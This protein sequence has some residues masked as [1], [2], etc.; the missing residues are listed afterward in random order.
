MAMTGPIVIPAVTAAMNALRV[1]S[2]IMDGEVAV[3]DENGI[4]SFDLL[5][6]GPRVKPEAT[7]CAFDLIELNGEDLRREALER[8]KLLLER[9][10]GAGR[11]GITFC[12][13]VIGDGAEIFRR[14]CELG[15]EG[16]V[17]KRRGSRYRSGRS[18]DR[19]KSKN[20]A[21]PAVRREAEED[22]SK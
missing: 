19:R 9:L 7:F 12:D 1:Q 15:L 13:H 10:L 20:P 5:R 18:L 8:R 6:S 2:C 17:S 14:V 21:S 4:R 16:I 3:A 11:P 22:W